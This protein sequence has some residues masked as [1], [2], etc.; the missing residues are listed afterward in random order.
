MPLKNYG[1]LVGRGSGQSGG[2][3]RR[4]PSL[5]SA[6][7]AAP[8]P[9]S[10]WPSTC[11]RKEAP[12]RAAVRRRGALQPSSA[13]ALATLPEGFTEVPSQ[14]GGVALDYIRGNLFDRTAMRP[15]AGHRTG[16]RQR[17]SGQARS[18]R[19]RAGIADPRRAGLRLRRA[20]GSGERQAGQDLRLRPR[21]RG[22]RHPHEPGQQHRVRP[23]RRRLAGRRAAVALS[24]PSSGWRSSWPSRVRP[25]TPM[26]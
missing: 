1:V 21:Q 20:V 19:R 15:D 18:L 26:I 23:R 14:R 9:I 7:P 3:R 6:H 12:S 8:I 2:G 11:C 22:A 13:S 25:G 24:R 4:Q 17:S 16:S 10:G 5:S